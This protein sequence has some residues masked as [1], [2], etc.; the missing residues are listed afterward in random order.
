MNEELPKMVWL[1]KLHFSL[2]I[3]SIIYIFFIKYTAIVCYALSELQ[4]RFY[5]FVIVYFVGVLAL[6]S[7]HDILTITSCDQMVQHSLVI[8]CGQTNIYT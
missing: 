8:Y 5:L 1:K 2:W 7:L 4:Y 6:L 3:I